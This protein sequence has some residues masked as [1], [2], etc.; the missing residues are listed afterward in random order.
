MFRR[1]WPTHGTLTNR[2]DGGIRFDEQ[3]QFGRA[4]LEQRQSAVEFEAEDVQPECAARAQRRNRQRR[5]QPPGVAPKSLLG[6][7]LTYLRS[8]WP[9]LIRY[10]ENGDRPI[11]NNPCE[12]AIRPFCVGRRWWLFSDTVDGA[13]ASANLYTFVVTCKANGIDPYRYLT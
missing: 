3:P 4:A 9:K 8:Q 11:S 7:G 12:N 13:H 10:I 6:K 2:L 1:C 5:A